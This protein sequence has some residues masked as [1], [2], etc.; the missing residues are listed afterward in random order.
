MNIYIFPFKKQNKGKP[1]KNI[2]NF[3]SLPIQECHTTYPLLL[4]LSTEN[5]DEG[6]DN[7]DI[8]TH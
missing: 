1:S 4:S 5:S 8:L 6:V 7:P 2:F 3:I